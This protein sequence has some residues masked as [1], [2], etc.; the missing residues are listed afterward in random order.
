MIQGF[1]KDVFGAFGRVFARQY[2][3]AP[4]VAAQPH[5]PFVWPTVRRR[6][7]AVEQ[8]S[9]PDRIVDSEV[10]EVVVVVSLAVAEAAGAAAGEGEQRDEADIHAFAF[11][12]QSEDSVGP[13]KLAYVAVAELG[14]VDSAQVEKSGYY[15]L[16]PLAPA[17]APAADGSEP[18]A[19]SKP[20]ADAPVVGPYTAVVAGAEARRNPHLQLRNSAPAPMAARLRREGKGL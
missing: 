9:A 5:K 19:V 13:L 12:E 4:C 7:R 6:G 15:P 20:S 17:P 1:G 3:P 2:V 18:S 14:E 10:A 11:E 16:T 8:P